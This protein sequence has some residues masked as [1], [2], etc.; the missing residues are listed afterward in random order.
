MDIKPRKVVS[1][2]MKHDIHDELR[3]IAHKKKSSIS[4]LIEGQA[5]NLIRQEKKRRK[6][7]E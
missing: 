5:V 3:K 4:K 1:V 7:D 2:R 6:G